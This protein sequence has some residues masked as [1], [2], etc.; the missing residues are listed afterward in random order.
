MFKNLMIVMCVLFGMSVSWVKADPADPS[1]KTFTWSNPV[2]FEDGTTVQV[3]G[4]PYVFGGS[5]F[6]WKL[7][8]G[9]DKYGDPN[10][11]TI[12]DPNATSLNADTLPVLPDGSY[13]GAMTGFDI[14]GIESKY[15]EDVVSFTVVGGKLV[16][17]KRSNPPT[18]LKKQ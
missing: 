17:F 16:A 6:Y 15:S 13:L 9:T 11:F 5:K 10:S 18:N 3:D 4:T 14:N 8:N 1:L 12:S 2:D 7:N